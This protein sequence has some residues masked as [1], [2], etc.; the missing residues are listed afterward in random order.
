[1]LIKNILDHTITLHYTYVSRIYTLNRKLKK[2]QHT[3]Y[4]SKISFYLCLFNMYKIIS[5]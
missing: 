2:K 5:C 4:I 1:M 3:L